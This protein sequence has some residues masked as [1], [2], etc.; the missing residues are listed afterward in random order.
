MTKYINGA[1][2]KDEATVAEE[3]ELDIVSR[4]QLDLANG[5]KLEAVLRRYAWNLAGGLDARADEIEAG[6]EEALPG[7][8]QTPANAAFVTGLRAA[9]DHIRNE[10]GR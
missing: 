7:L 10:G 5:A 3:R 4:L 1:T 6:H 9:G 8:A 2:F